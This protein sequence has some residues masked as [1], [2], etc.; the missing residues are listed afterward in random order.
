MNPSSSRG[1]CTCWG[2]AR[3][4]HCRPSSP[5]PLF[6]LF[7]SPHSQH[8]FCGFCGAPASPISKRLVQKSAESCAWTEAITGPPRRPPPPVGFPLPLG[9]HSFR[10]FA[11]WGHWLSSLRGLSPG[12]PGLFQAVDAVPPRVECKGGIG[13]A[14]APGLPQVPTFL[15]VPLA[16]SEARRT[17]GRQLTTPAEAC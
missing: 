17:D 13:W 3:S 7:T 4:L 15:S 5:C 14:D 11:W 12:L 6:P 9:P 16:G 1:A 8:G 2:G 10:C